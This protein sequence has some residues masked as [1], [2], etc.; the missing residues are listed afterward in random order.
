MNSK[1]IVI[2]ESQYTDWLDGTCRWFDFFKELLAV[3]H[4]AANQFSSVQFNTVAGLNDS[5][6]VVHLQTMHLGCQC[7]ANSSL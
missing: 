7:S 2:N 4:I 5:G 3:V 1:K 6:Q